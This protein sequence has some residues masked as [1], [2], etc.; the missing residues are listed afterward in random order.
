MGF[1]HWDVVGEL[2]LVYSLQNRQPLANGR[3][4]QRF[5]V[6]WTEFTQGIPL[7]LVLCKQHVII[8]HGDTSSKLVPRIWL[9]YWG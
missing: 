4:A 7:H 9:S 5:E 3:D 8:E 1:V 6:S 2:H